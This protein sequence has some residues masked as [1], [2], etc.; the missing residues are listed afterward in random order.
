[1][2]RSLATTIPALLV[3]IA[4]MLGWSTGAAAQDCS[5]QQP[6]VLEESSSRSEIRCALDRSRRAVEVLGRTI[7]VIADDEPV[8]GA[9]CLINFRFDS[10]ELTPASRQLVRRIV[11]VILEDKVLRRA[12]F[13]ID[14]HTDAVGTTAYN[15]A[16]GADRAST[17][18][19]AFELLGIDPENMRSRSLGES[20]LLD[21][22]DPGA[23]INRRVEITPYL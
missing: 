16:L 22:D 1:M 7:T 3:V 9:A 4:C 15:L 5:R 17:V 20:D 6:R 19:G 13:L 2:N 11:D 14:G 10:S 12:T 23:A 8:P 18:R 21:A